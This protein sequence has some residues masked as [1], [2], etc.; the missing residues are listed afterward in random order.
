MATGFDLTLSPAATAAREHLHAVAGELRE[1]AATA[2]AEG[3]DLPTLRA[4]LAAAGLDPAVVA[5]AGIDPLT[6]LVALDALA[7][8]DP[9]AAWAIVPALQVATIV[10]AVGT[11]EQK[12]AVS[13][14]LA[15]PAATASLLAYEDYGRQPSEYETTVGGGSATGRKTS[16]AW[17]A[18]ADVS[19]LVGREGDEIVAHCWT[20]A[21]SGITVERDDRVLGKIAV[22]A[23]PSG[24]VTL[25]G[26]ATS[27]GER[28]GGGLALDRSL[29]QARLMLG[30]VLQGTARASIEFC[31]GYAT[32]RT[33][34]GVPIA[35]HQGVAFP[36]IDRTTELEKL[37]L[38]LWDT[39]AEV[40]RATDTADIEARV[41]RALNRIST[42][43]LHTTRDG[44]QLVGVRA[45]TRD[46]PSERWYR[47]AAALGVVDVDIAAT[48]FS[49]SN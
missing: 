46:L 17:P 22:T 19:L 2:E 9:G 16:V 13:A 4:H 42:H 23:A 27:P 12:A 39:S 21:R 10:A 1:Q 36:I 31:A 8:G 40:D 48:P 20:G 25:D 47:S 34:W 15:S 7:Y 35:Q 5:Q 28:L 11:P 43:A 18:G 6:V 32:A 30:A 29:G 26:V 3:V 24:T 37:R 44:V 49:L 45:I 38:L 14:A 33:T 41:A